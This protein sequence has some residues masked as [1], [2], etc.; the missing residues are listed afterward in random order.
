MAYDWTT[1]GFASSK[2]QQLS[3]GMLLALINPWF[4]PLGINILQQNRIFVVCAL[5]TYTALFDVLP[6]YDPV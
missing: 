3:A 6:E 2:S 5:P 1:H 4:A